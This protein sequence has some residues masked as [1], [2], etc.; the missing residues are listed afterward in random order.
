MTSSFCFLLCVFPFK[1]VNW[2]I[3]FV[4]FFPLSFFHLQCEALSGLGFRRGSYKC[5]CRKGFY[6]PD[7]I[8]PQKYFNGSTLEEEYEKLMLVSIISL[9]RKHWKS[10]VHS[11]ELKKKEKKLSP[12]CFNIG[13]I[14]GFYDD[15]I[16]HVSFCILRRSI[17]LMAPIYSL[18]KLFEP[19]TVAN[20]IELCE[21]GIWIGI[22]IIP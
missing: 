6:F 20:L 11:E 16:N 14:S 5:V 2:W 17:Y 4:F 7:T 15:D 12:I 10:Y 22:R 21:C 3:C 8:L 13:C 18:S 1:I 19:Q 9:H